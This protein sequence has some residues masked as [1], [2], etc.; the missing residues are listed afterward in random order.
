MMDKLHLNNKDSKITSEDNKDTKPDQEVL[1]TIGKR[2][3]ATEVLVADSLM[4]ITLLVELDQSETEGSRTS[5][6]TTTVKE[7]TTRMSDQETGNAQDVKSITSPP[8]S[9]A[10]SVIPLREPR[11]SLDNNNQL[12]DKSLDN[13]NQSLVVLPV[14]K[15]HQLVEMVWDIRL[16][17]TVIRRMC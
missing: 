10:S 2:V 17:L 3:C 7:E 6:E 4:T 15:W 1:V 14:D 11:P 8:E 9:N 12:L 13:N 5:V 16:S